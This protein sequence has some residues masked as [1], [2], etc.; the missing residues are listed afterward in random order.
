MNFSGGI[1][2]LVDGIVGGDETCWLGWN[3]SPVSIQ[4]QFDQSRHFKTIQIYT[5]NNKYSLIEVKFDNDRSF[6]H[7]PH[8]ILS[9]ISTVFLETIDLSQYGS[10]FISEQIEIRFRFH[11]EIFLLT[12][13]KFD[14]EIATATLFTSTL[15]TTTLC[16]TGNKKTKLDKRREKSFSFSF[17]D[18]FESIRIV[19]L[20]DFYI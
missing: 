18:E 12:E 3:S 7:R 16:S 17:N 4:F 10:M 15:N 20:S 9:T 2:K 5:M 11:D 6:E 13:I 19:V 8:P 14:N 1:G